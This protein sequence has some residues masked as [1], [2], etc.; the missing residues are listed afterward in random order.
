MTDGV[1]I[2]RQRLGSDDAEAA[3]VAP[4]ET[5]T[6]RDDDDD[7]D[8]DDAADDDDGEGTRAPA[9]RIAIPYREDG[10]GE[11]GEQLSRLL[12]RLA[13]MFASRR[14]RRVAV[15]VVVAT[16]SR[17]GRRFNRGQ[18]RLISQHWSP[19]DRVGVVNAVP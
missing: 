17:D 4:A 13:T 1:V 18:V 11:R 10:S 2:T 12:A 9:L 16:Q 7:D 8:D 14:R 6:T 19:Y 5:A 15:V 3:V